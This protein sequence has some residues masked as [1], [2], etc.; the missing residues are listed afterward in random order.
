MSTEKV[1]V[2]ASR[3]PR[4]TEL[5]T[6]VGVNHIVQPADI[7]ESPLPNEDPV[8]YVQRISREK[9][10]VVQSRVQ[11]DVVVLAADTTVDIDGVILGQPVDTDHARA[12]LLQLSGRTHQVHTGVTVLSGNQEHSQVVSSEVT[13]LALTPELLDWYL[14]TGESA[15]KAGAYAIQGH[16]AALVE[17][18]V[19]SMSN[20]IGLPLDETL[21]LL[22]AA[23]E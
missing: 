10:Q 19:G 17:A 13:F 23:T 21:L 4:R 5:L 11:S 14:G 2:L 22:A 18:T 15:G 12:M 6:S 16:G 8:V 7:D 9:A 3:S 1:L 20:I